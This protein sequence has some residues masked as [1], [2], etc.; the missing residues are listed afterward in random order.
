MTG[1]PYGSITGRV[2]ISGPGED[3]HDLIQVSHPSP[4]TAG[5][6]LD[7][8]RISDLPPGTYQAS[9]A[10]QVVTPDGQGYWKLSDFGKVYGFGSYTWS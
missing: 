6:P 1:L 2:T 5:G 10:G 3:I 9:A 4:A 8:D 7:P